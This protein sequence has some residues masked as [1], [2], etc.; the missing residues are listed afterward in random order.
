M[1]EE[2]SGG[3]ATQADEITRILKENGFESVADM[4]ADR[5]KAGSERDKFSGNN[6]EARE[7]IQRKASEIDQLRRELEAEKAKGTEA[8][9]PTEPKVEDPPAKEETLEDIKASLKPEQLQAADAAY[10]ALPETGDW[11]RQTIAGSEDLQKKLFKEASQVATAVPESL[12]T[13]ANTE[14]KTDDA[15]T[16]I[17]A[18]FGN[19]SKRNRFVPNGPSGS[20]IQGQPAKTGSKRLAGT[21]GD[22]VLSAL[23]DRDA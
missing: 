16:R 21:G 11:S 9:K 19:E 13:P 8:P 10:K 4:N 5:L 20:P 15:D 22:G 1:A 2:N 14:T 17:A 18:M 23:K 12:L 7:I 3:D 6:D